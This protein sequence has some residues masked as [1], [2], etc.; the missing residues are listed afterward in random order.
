[1]KSKRALI[2]SGIAL[3]L[4]VTLMAAG[5]YALFSDTVT[6]SAHL[7]AGT[8]DITMKRTSLV[9]NT[10]DST[11]GYMT[12]NRNTT[13]A[14]AENL[15]NLFDLTESTRIAPGSSFTATLSIENNSDVAFTYWAEIVNSENSNSNLSEQ[16]KVTVTVGDN[17]YEGTLSDGRITVGSASAPIG[18][19]A[20]GQAAQSFT[21]TVEF[22]TLNTN[23]LA[24]NETVDFDLV[25]YA[26]QKTAAPA[27]Q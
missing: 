19:M 14:L 22:L 17:T 4:C 10:L 12:E 13:P 11:T 21:V 5:S 23:D 3:L 16:L 6:G 26:V 15:D 27:Q 9:T 7:Q 24:Q 20:K 2:L 18:E 8:L 25:V 1:M